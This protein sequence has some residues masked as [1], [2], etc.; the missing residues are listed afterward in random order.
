MIGTFD[1]GMSLLKIINVDTRNTNQNDAAVLFVVPPN[2]AMENLP[3]AS[4]CGFRNL[5]NVS[6]ASFV[7]SISSKAM[8]KH[9]AKFFERI[10]N[11][12]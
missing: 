5:S 11:F 10:N 3:H 9:A 8:P 2:P 12:A 4:V 7:S 6:M 1:A